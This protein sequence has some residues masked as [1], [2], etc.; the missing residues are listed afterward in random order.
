M[1]PRQRIEAALKHKQPDRTP[2]FEY[3]LLSPLADEFLGRPYAGE[4]MKN[5]PAML[6]EK[7]WEGAVR[8]NA[9]DRLDLAELLGHDMMYVIP[10]PL[11]TDTRGDSAPPPQPF[12]DEP[13]KEVSDRNDK[14]AQQGVEP[15]QDTFLIYTFLN[16]E[17]QRRGID[18]P[19]IAPAYEHGVWT[20][21]A[22]M[23]TMLLNPEVA[24]RHFSLATEKCFA[25]IELYLSLGID[26]IGVGGDFAGNAPMISPKA[27][28]E[29]IVPEVR[30]LSRKIHEAGGYAINTSDGNLWPVID[31]FLIGCEVDGYLEIDMHAGMDLKKLK[32]SYG[33]RVTLYG[34]LDC[35]NILSF[36]ST[37]DVKAHVTEC[38][39]AAQGNG[40]HILC[41]SN[42]ISASVSMENYIT[43]IN[44][45]RDIF[46]IEK[47]SF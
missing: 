34:N 47:L 12:S 3:V 25:A 15:P 18:L 20:D 26:Q 22:L 17:M 1:T 37:D 38:L 8:Q 36:G 40:G 4:D 45:Y 21:V 39:E 44:T 6:K 42:A 28:K 35:G 31:D 30:K 7:G 14:L 5:W 9:I 23:Q 32:D 46:S 13:V 11:P 27:Y 33:D 16:E 43:A 29:F 2:Y 24:H 19:I 10:N 41:A